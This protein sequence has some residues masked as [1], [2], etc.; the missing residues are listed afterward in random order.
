MTQ[1]PEHFEDTAPNEPEPQT[2]VRET[3]TPVWW[4]IAA[5]AVLTLIAIGSI[6]VWLL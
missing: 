2:F 5:L 1:R 6:V 3:P 4:I